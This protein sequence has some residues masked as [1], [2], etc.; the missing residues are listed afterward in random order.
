MWKLW[1]CWL[2]YSWFSCNDNIIYTCNYLNGVH[3]NNVYR[4]HW[5]TPFLRAPTISCKLTAFFHCRILATPE[6]RICVCWL[7]AQRHLF[8]FWISSL[9]VSSVDLYSPWAPTIVTHVHDIDSD[10]NYYLLT[11]G[12]TLP[13]H[14]LHNCG[15]ELLVCKLNAYTNTHLPASRFQRAFFPSSFADEFFPSLVRAGFLRWSQYPWAPTS[16]TF[17]HHVDGDTNYL[18]Q[19]HVQ[20]YLY[21]S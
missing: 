17:V 15:F 18:F 1:R 16:E 6:H 11:A 12:A 19:R 14:E 10:T 21:M 13:V 9:R 8:F 3:L 2:R 7:S 5:S 20:R 4:R